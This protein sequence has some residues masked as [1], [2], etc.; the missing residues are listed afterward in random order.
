MSNEIGWEEALEAFYGAQISDRQ[1]LV[2]E[3]Y[4]KAENTNSAELLAAIE[5]AAGDGMKPA[6]WRVTVRDLRQWLKIYRAREFAA[7]NAEA[8]EARLEAFVSE[9]REK[10]KRGAPRDDMLAAAEGL[11]V[12]IVR[13]N[14][15][16]REILHG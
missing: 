9:W 7:R 4:L 3:H 12:K 6:E 2:W 1:V 14:D 16:I 11:P 10:L 5:M 15:L 8:S 13:K